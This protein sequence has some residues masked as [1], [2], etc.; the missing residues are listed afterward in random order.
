MIL[1]EFIEL[2]KEIKDNECDDTC[3]CSWKE[4]HKDLP[5]LFS[6][7]SI[8]GHKGDVCQMLSNQSHKHCVTDVFSP[9]AHCKELNLKLKAFI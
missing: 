3:R 4:F 6:N 1:S 9:T 5:L 7:S 2:L 8:S